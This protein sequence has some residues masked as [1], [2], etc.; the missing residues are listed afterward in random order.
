[1]YSYLKP[2]FFLASFV[3]SNGLGVRFSVV[4]CDYDTFWHMNQP[5]L[6]H[7][8]QAINTN[9]IYSTPCNE[10]PKPIQTCRGGRMT[11]PTYR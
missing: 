7:A 9:F 3:S 10:A 8:D 5:R 4:L 11:L 6:G 2:G 1:M